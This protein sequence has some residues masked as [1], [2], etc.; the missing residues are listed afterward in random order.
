MSVEEI[1][2]LAEPMVLITIESGSEQHY[3]LGSNDVWVRRGA[4][5]VRPRPGTT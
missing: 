3:A 5:N 4:S 1:R 2:A